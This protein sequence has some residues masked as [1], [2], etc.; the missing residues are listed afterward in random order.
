MFPECFLKV[1]Y[2]FPE[3]SLNVPCMFPECSLHVGLQV[4]YK[5]NTPDAPPLLSINMS[6]CNIG[7][8][9]VIEVVVAL[10]QNHKLQE[11]Y[12]QHNGITN[13]GKP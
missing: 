4:L 13:K 9:G 1:P 7:D 12:L 2:M 11:L 6:H 10:E 3:C 8:E 5:G